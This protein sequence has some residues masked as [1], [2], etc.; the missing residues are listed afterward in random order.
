MMYNVYIKSTKVLVGWLSDKAIQRNVDHHF[1]MYHRHEKCVRETN[2][3]LLD[4]IGTRP[5]ATFTE[6]TQATLDTINL[7]I[8]RRP[9]FRDGQLEDTKYFVTVDLKNLRKLKKHL[10]FC[11]FVD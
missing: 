9:I 5:T 7:Q 10:D 11:E 3:P 1:G 6:T 2:I 8:Q 4:E